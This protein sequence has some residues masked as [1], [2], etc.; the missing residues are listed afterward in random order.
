MMNTKQRVLVVDDEPGVIRFV[1][2]NLTLA[3]FEVVTTTSGEEALPLIES[4]KPD[5]LLLDILM[6]PI[7]GF[8]ILVELR[9]FSQLPVIVFTARNDIGAIAIKEGA[10]G[11]IAKPFKPDELIK[12]I[13]EILV[14]KETDVR[15]DGRLT[16][17]EES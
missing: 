13:Q 5:I 15:V 11:F 4:E 16:S 6:T 2:I 14:A 12:K 1:K 7:T 3:G 9:T 10:N 17:P 8:D